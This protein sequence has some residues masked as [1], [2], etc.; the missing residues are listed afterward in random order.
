MDDADSYADAHHSDLA[1]K[2]LEV[3]RRAGAAVSAS[4]GRNTVR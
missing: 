2:K 3:R 4:Y 1:H